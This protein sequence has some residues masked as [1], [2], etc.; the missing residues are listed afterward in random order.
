MA[1]QVP[2][3]WISQV[4]KQIKED[5]VYYIKYFQVSNARASFRPVDHPYMIRFTAYTKT[6]EVKLISDMFPL[7]A[8]NP[9]SFDVLDSRAGKTEQ[10]LGNDLLH[11]PI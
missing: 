6:T 1:A 7:Y 4:K 3:K 8:C 11:H 9:V 5:F 2:Q 10:T